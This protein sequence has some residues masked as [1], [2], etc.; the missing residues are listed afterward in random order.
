MSHKTI[1]SGLNASRLGLLALTP[2]MAAMM[3]GA[4]TAEAAAPFTATAKVKAG[5]VI[6]AGKTAKNIPE[7]ARISVYDASNQMILYTANTDSKKAFNF[8]LLSA[9]TVPCL[10]R[11]EMTNPDNNAVSKANLAV[12]GAPKSC[13]ATAPPACVIK[14]PDNDKQVVIGD[15]VNFEPAAIKTKKAV[16][17]TWSISDGTADIATSNASH[18]FTSAGRYKVTLKSTAASGA[19]CTDDV[20]I[21]VIPPATTN[22]GRVPEQAKPASASAMPNNGGNDNGAYVVLPFEEM[23]MQGGS[24]ISLPYNAMINYNSLNAQVIQK[25]PHKPPI[26][27][28]TNVDVFY[29]AASNDKDPIASNS[30]NSTSQNLFDSNVLGPNWDQKNS[31]FSSTTQLPTD[32]KF[33]AGQDYNKA[34]IRKSEQWDR[35]HQPINEAYKSLSIEDRTK[36][37]NSLAIPDLN[38]LHPDSAKTPATAAYTAFKALTKAEKVTAIISMIDAGTIKRYDV[39]AATFAE[40][41]NTFTPA[42]P[43]EKPDQGIR[44]YV[45]G[46]QG[47]R[48]M[49]GISNPFVANDP[50]SIPFNSYQDAFVA[51][52]IPVSDID[53]NGR[54]NPYPLLR[55]QAKDKSGNTIATTD[56]VYTTASETRCREC[57]TPGGLAADENVWRMPVSEDELKD[58]VD[59]T[60]PGPATGRGKPGTGGPNISGFVDGTDASKSWPPAIHNK[61]DNKNAADATYTNLGVPLTTADTS[62]TNIKVDQNGLRT[63]RVKASR[64]VKLD[65]KGFPTNET[66]A[67][68][69][70]NADKSWRLQIQVKFYDYSKYGATD[71][72]WVNQ[73]KAALFNTLIMHDYMVKYGPTP[74]T[75]SDWPASFSTQVADN[76]GGDDVGKSPVTPMYFCSGHHQ[77]QLKFDVGVNGGAG[78]FATNRSDY[79]RAFHAFHG[80]MQVYKDN[81]TAAQSADGLVHKKGDLIRDVRGH[82]LEFGGRGWDSQK[83]DDNGVPLKQDSSGN[84]TVPTTQ[85]YN[86]VKNNWDPDLY[87]M[88]EFGTSMLPFGKNV[89]V[90]ENCAK[91]H[92]GPTEKSYR[93]IHHTVGL[94][95]ESCHK[96]MLAVGNV[97][98]NEKYNAN[99]TGGGAYGPDTASNDKEPADFRRPWLDE[100]NCG[101]CHIGDGNMS[102]SD[103]HFFSSGA[104]DQAWA[105]GDKTGYSTDPMNARF[106]VMP[107]TSS[108]GD[109]ENRPEK[110]TATADDVAVAAAKGYKNA[111]GETIKVGDAFYKPMPLSGVLYRKSG[112]V[113]GSGANGTLTCSTCHGGSHAIWPNQDPNANDNQT[114]KQLQGYD[115]NIAECSV[116][117]VKN[118]FVTGLVAT[119]GGKSG[120]GVGQGVRDGTVV[121][122]VVGDNTKNAY[123]AGP[124][125]LHPIG[126]ES[127]Y[128]YADSTE[129]SKSAGKHLANVNGGWH[130]DMAKKPGPDGEDQCAACHGG[131]HKG[132]RLS[133]TL[134]S[135]DL[136]NDKGKI[137]KVVKGQ[138]IGCNL[139]HTLAKSY[140]G[141]PVPYNARKAPTGGWPE[142]KMHMPPSPGT[143]TGTTVTGGG[144]M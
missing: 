126:D 123:L 1:K 77:S 17:H 113:H 63:D 72:S 132:T 122:P 90:E 100:P 135:R 111:L 129:A 22:P 37:L 59:P 138:I 143:F 82:P 3:A 137:V 28:N 70:E 58:Y 88:H 116:C 131:D 76:Y 26:I 134:K 51:Q 47:V 85:T 119:D 101:S 62:L 66:S 29:S 104:L 39:T 52:F 60:K 140:T 24:Q 15:T 33:I 106:A 127:W 136:T 19:Q 49:P 14:T 98:S 103:K 112:D 81:V 83:D 96:D 141:S 40:K 91:C 108:L 2:I 102:K 93:D 43:V 45:D 115:G 4:P 38:S 121:A 46:G 86:V 110:L 23:G 18:V 6:V 78:K 69:P 97:Y 130:N 71:N 10:V 30:I 53:D 9:S 65:S 21:S 75:G 42:L 5:K 20:I 34:K 64:W 92:T 41:Q 124:H 35:M 109:V 12:S 56:A 7:N 11:I 117:H 142:A 99:L 57:H 87:P 36:L 68:K 27:S 144:H 16:T 55:V 32:I 31:K 8:K 25:L 13:A 120:L 44:G 54:T 94:T 95:C 73:E 67:T 80:K 139:C 50:Q 125:G 74:A 79:S 128:K 89:P 114:A 133:K 48:Q 84:F 107:T 118:D 105:D 61:F